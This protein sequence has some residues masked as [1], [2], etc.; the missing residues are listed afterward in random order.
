MKI[1]NK[2]SVLF[3]IALASAFLFS[4]CSLPE[5]EKKDVLKI[6]EIRE[7]LF[8]SGKVNKMAALLTDDFPDRKEYLDQ[9]KYRNFYFTEYDYAINSIDF[10]SYNLLTKKTVAMVNFDLSFKVPESPADTVFLGRI[11]KVTLKKEEI[12]WKI[13]AIEEI[14]DSGKKIEP[15]LVYDIFHPLDSRKIA[16]SNGDFPLFE[17]VIHPDFASR[18]EFL[19]DFKKNSEFFSE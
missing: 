13:A 9:L 15:Q 7:D 16:I 1:A 3:F 6:L 17:S 8:N 18:E 10:L 12:G 2:I 14:S 11:E 4:S 19:S 5:N